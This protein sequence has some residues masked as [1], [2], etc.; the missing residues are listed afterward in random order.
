VSVWKICPTT[1]IFFWPR[2]C[3]NIP[4]WR[5]RSRSNWKR[6]ARTSSARL[7][8]TMAEHYHVLPHQVLQ[9]T[10]AEFY[11]NVL[12]MGLNR[13]GSTRQRLSTPPREREAGE[14]SLAAQFEAMMQAQSALNGSAH[15]GSPPHG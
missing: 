3:C 12:I 8:Q 13:D 2:L 11:L 6:F 10:P 15:P 9:T 14:L 1:I 7:V 4:G 5:R